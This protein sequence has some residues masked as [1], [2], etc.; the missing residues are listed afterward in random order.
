[1]PIFEYRCRDCEKVSEIVM[2]GS[3]DV[4]ICQ[5]CNSQNMEKLLSAHA[6]AS[7]P[8]KHVMPGPGD[9]G[10]CGSAPGQASHCAGP[11]SCCGRHPG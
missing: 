7:G 4:P 6:A 5:F 11:G 8:V 2:V 3:R 10:C 1:M 9:T